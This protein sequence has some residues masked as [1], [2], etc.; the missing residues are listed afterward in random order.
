[1]YICISLREP[2]KL[3]HHPIIASTFVQNGQS[4]GGSI[5]ANGLQYFIDNN[6]SPTFGY[7][8]YLVVISAQ[9]SYN[10]N[11]RNRASN[12]ANQLRNQKG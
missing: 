10:A 1:M 3:C 4:T 9:G 12:L 7:R 8:N 2:A 6:V 11:D 5:T